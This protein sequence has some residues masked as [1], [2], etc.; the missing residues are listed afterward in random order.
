[1][2][3]V[4][5]KLMVISLKVGYSLLIKDHHRASMITL[6]TST[7]RLQYTSKVKSTAMTVTFI[8]HI[9]LVHITTLLN[10]RMSSCKGYN[11]NTNRVGLIE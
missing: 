6:D 8:L 3:I 10:I 4:V 7:I 9:R 5:S 1:M 11:T 2:G